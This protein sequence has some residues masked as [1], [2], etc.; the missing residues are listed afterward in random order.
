M[1]LTFLPPRRNGIIFHLAAILLLFTASVLT[2]DQAT[3]TGIGPAFMAYLLGFTALALPIPIL[4]Y[5]LYA[6]LRSKYVLTPGSI[7]LSWGLRSEKIPMVEINWLRPEQELDFRLPLPL[8]RWPGAVTGNRRLDRRTLVEFLASQGAALILIETPNRAF[9]ISPEDPQAFLAAFHRMAELGTLA[10]EAGVSTRPARVLESIWQ[11]LSARY[12]L[13]S[14]LALALA[15]LGYVTF[16]VAPAPGVSHPLA[17]TGRSITSAQIFL[18]PVLNGVFYLADL[19]LGLI[20]FPRPT[21]RP[22]AFLLWIA[23]PLVSLMFFAAILSLF[24]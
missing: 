24:P 8:I 17:Q 5:Q 20:F 18:L 1:E 9:A 10:P 11:N 14:G 23:T 21:T 16:G 4:A 12:L 13:L 19:F 7:T 3:Y 22:L 6:L 2:L 15:F